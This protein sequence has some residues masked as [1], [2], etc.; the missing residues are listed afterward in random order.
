MAQA[1]NR[2]IVL[3]AR[4]EGAPGDTGCRLEETPI[5]PPRDGELRIGQPK[6]GETVAV[7]AA[8][9]AVGAVS[10]P[11]SRGAR[12]GNPAISSAEEG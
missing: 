4:P 5:P 1:R 3:A 8:S 10:F 9:G 6:E 12:S 2:R 7:S 11:R